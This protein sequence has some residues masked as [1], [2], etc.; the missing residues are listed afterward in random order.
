MPQRG[1]DLVKVCVRPECSPES[2]PSTY[3]EFAL[4]ASSSGSTGRRRSQTRTARSAP[5]TPT[6]TWT[7]NVLLRHATYFSPSPTRR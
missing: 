6:W 5:C 2:R 4:I 3:G 7:E 1:N